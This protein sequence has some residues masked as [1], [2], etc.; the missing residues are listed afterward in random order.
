MVGMGFSNLVAFFIMLTTA[1]TLNHQGVTDIQTS[2]QAAAAL[3]PVAGNFAF[4]LFALGIIGT[5]FLAIPVLA[6]SAAYATA[7]AFRWQDGLELRPSQAKGFYSIIALSTLVGIVL[8]FTPLDPIKALFWSAVLNGV[9][10][11]PIMAVM[12]LMA[13]NPRVM[14]RFTVSRRLQV[15]GWVATAAMAV[16]VAAMFVTL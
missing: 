15:A 6:G 4:A 9:I 5:G 11:V 10:S 3:K 13:V 2:A 7:G 14:G 12:M 16:A 1:L 8:G